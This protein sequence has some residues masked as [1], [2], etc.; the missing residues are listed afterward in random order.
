MAESDENA[1]PIEANRELELLLQKFRKGTMGMLRN[2]HFRRIVI[3]QKLGLQQA[4]NKWEW[5][6]NVDN[7]APNVAIPTE[8]E[9]KKVA[10]VSSEERD[11]DRDAQNDTPGNKVNGVFDCPYCGDKVSCSVERKPTSNK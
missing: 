10:P 7:K 11:G 8:S 5:V 4:K 1:T 9:F 6:V 3:Q 2:E